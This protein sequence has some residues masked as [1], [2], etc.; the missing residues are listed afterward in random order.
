MRASKAMIPAII[1]AIFPNFKSE[2]AFDQ[3]RRWRF[4]WAIPEIKVAIEYEGIMVDAGGKSRH[5]TADGY[6]ADC[7]KYNAAAIA[8]WV[9]LRYTAKN[10]GD[11]QRDLSSVKKYMG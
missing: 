3:V 1:R 11:L 9:V 4:D 8:G 6:T 7:E 10:I 5:T 2:Y